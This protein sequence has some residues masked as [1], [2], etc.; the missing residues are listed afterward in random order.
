MDAS[1]AFVCA[2]GVQADQGGLAGGQVF[3]TGLASG[4]VWAKC[5]L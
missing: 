3:L 1:E 4:S 5:L 2:G